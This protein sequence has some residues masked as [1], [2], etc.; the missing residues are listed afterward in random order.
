MVTR[1]SRGDIVFVICL[2]LLFMFLIIAASLIPTPTVKPRAILPVE[3][4]EDV[5]LS[6][7]F[8]SSAFFTRRPTC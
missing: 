5:T 2:A 4:E 6:L 1:N 3:I 8:P 7:G